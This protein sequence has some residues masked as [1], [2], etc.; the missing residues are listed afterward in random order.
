MS[1]LSSSDLPTQSRDDA[2]RFLTCL[3]PGSLDF[4][5]QTFP[6]KA[7]AEARHFPCDRNYI[8]RRPFE[9]NAAGAGLS[10]TINETRNQ[11][12]K[13]EDVTRIRAV[14]GEGGGDFPLPPSLVVTVAPTRDWYCWLVEDDWPADSETIAG[15]QGR[16]DFERV[17]ES[18]VSRYGC[19]SGATDIGYA[20]R[21]PGTLNQEADP[22]VV[23]MT[24]PACDDLVKRYPRSKIMKSFAVEA[25]SPFDDEDVLK[26]GQALH[27]ETGGSG[28]GF[29][30]WD[31]WLR[32]TMLAD[33][34]PRELLRTWASFK[35]AKGP[36]AEQTI[37]ELKETFKLWGHEPSAAQWNGL[38]DLANGLE[39]MTNGTAGHLYYLS[40]LDP[41]IGKTQTVVHFCRVLLAT[42]AYKGVSVLICVGRLAEIESY[43]SDM[44]L[45]GDE[46]AVLVSDDPKN[47]AL[48][49]MGNRDRNNARVLFTT[50]QMLEARAKRHGSFAGISEFW[51]DSKPRQV[52]LW[53]EAC[54]PARPLTIDVTIIE[55]MTD[56]ARRQSKPL[57]T[58][59]RGLI[60]SIEKADNDAFVTIPDFEECGIDL[61]MALGIFSDEKRAVR[62]AVND[63]FLLSGKTVVVKKQGAN[64]TFVHY[65]NSLPDDLKPVVVCDASG[66]V[67]SRYAHWSKGR[68]DLIRLQQAEKDYSNLTIHLW[69]R[70]GSKDA[71]K[72]S[73]DELLAGV[74]DAVNSKPDEPFLIVHHKFDGKRFRLDVAAEI[75]KRAIN[76]ERLRFTHWGGDDCRATNEFK[77]FPNIVLAGTMFY[78]P[79]L[80]E[81]IGRLSR[82]L[83]SNERLDREHRRQIEDGEHANLILQAVCRGAVRKSEG[84]GCAPC[85][86]YLIA[87]RQHGIAQMLEDGYIFPGAK[88]AEWEPVKK[89]LTGYLAEAV[90]YVID[91]LQNS[92]EDELSLAA[93]RDGIA[94]A[95]KDNFNK[96]VAKHPDFETTMD[97]YGI[98]IDRRTGRLG[99]R[100]VRT[101]ESDF[102]EDDSDHDRERMYPSS[103]A[104]GVQQ[105]AEGTTM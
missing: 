90:D 77:D 84:S 70:A 94:M 5:F 61:N 62:D 8:H 104:V 55:G 4:V 41:G 35:S 88:I 13:G 97:D 65:E 44:G 92:D 64:G 89:K 30:L 48:N 23:T 32:A 47:A 75:T 99:S 14:W 71:W 50:Q 33:F 79:S 37:R 25:V 28:D 60:A 74:I 69:L 46:Y 18:A 59:L 42:E 38:R 22:F 58:I 68:G 95:D 2:L 83:A 21:L 24:E 63:L 15:Q 39:A 57:H 6:D 93:V 40:S 45:A 86:V 103:A 51:Y 72:R 98:K 78:P 80:Y 31:R 76:P 102:L 3:D 29:G 43:V 11:S 82:G 34:D 19:N 17:M 85:E 56:E 73:P 10:V 27:Q 67:H 20:L 49:T 91:W 16:Q 105:I 26:I 9:A 7:G 100:L 52:R 87:S 101:V 54:L 1:S 53:D 96:L 36:L 81:A 66:R 12:R